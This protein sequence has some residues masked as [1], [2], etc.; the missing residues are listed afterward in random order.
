MDL[1]EKTMLEVNSSSDFFNYL[2]WILGLYSG[3]LGLGYGIIGV[4]EYSYSLIFILD[5]IGAFGYSAYF[6]LISMVLGS[7]ISV[8]FPIL[9]A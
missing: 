4:V 8:F 5:T 6:Y 7:F 2:T 1:L 3:V 9:L